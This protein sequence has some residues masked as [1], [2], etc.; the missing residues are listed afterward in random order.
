MLRY[1]L[2]GRS[3][4]VSSRLNAQRI[5]EHPGTVVR[6]AEA[7]EPAPLPSFGVAERGGG[8]RW[9]PSDAGHVEPF[10]EG[11]EAAAFAETSSGE[12][13]RRGPAR[14]RAG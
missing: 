13:V 12:R 2:L 14:R 4:S 5:I 10:A 1:S 9:R 8:G 7:V 6:L 11:A 3:L